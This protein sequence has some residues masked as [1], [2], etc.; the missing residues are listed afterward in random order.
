MGQAPSHLVRVDT[1]TGRV[2]AQRAVR[3]PQGPYG[4]LPNWATTGSEVI[5]L[6]GDRS[7]ALVLDPDT[8]AERDAIPLPANAR[9]ELT[10]DG[11]LR[12][13]WISHAL[14]SPDQL[15]GITTATGVTR[16]DLTPGTAGP[17]RPVGPCGVWNAVQPTRSRLV[18]MLKCTNQLG[19]L[20]LESGKLHVVPSIQYEADLGQ[21]DDRVWMR[22]SELGFVGVLSHR[23]DELQTLDLN[24]EGPLLGGIFNIQRA[25]GSIWVT[26]RPADP[27]LPGVV[28]RIDPKKVVV[29]ARAWTTDAVAVTERRGFGYRDGRIVAWDPA[30]V[31]GGAPKHA[32]RPSPT[33]PVRYR[34]RTSGE[35]A[36]RDAFMTVFDPETSNAAAAPFLEDAA[37]LA[38]VRTALAATAQQ[39]PGVEVVVTRIAINGARAAV[40]YSLAVDGMLA[41]VPLTGAAER[42]D[43]RWVVTRSSLCR[44]AAV[45][46]LPGC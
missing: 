41:F 4:M 3:P 36:V 22:W 27:A 42:V 30:T 18:V 34:P 37:S 11:K 21:V 24:A 46:N 45:A 17:M 6:D 32:V 43:G 28:Y 5:L 23:G 40:A 33:H 9:A 10:D 20:D 7:T 29:T 31:D 39:F 19:V 26:G 25:A 13:V 2:V 12:A 35:R 14:R 8:L 16:L 1:R 44:L 38:N 15:A